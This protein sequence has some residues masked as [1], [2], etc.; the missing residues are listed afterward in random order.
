VAPAAEPAKPR[1]R[2]ASGAGNGKA[3]K[4]PAKAKR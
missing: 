4:R 1:K 2:A 3:S